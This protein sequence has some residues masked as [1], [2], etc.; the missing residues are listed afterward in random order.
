MSIP[1]DTLCVLLHSAG[2][3]D[4]GAKAPNTYTSI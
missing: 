4:Q 1:Q 2:E 3:T